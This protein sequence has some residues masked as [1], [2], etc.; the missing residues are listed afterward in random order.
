[1]K[2]SKLTAAFCAI[3]LMFCLVNSEAS[4]T[5]KKTFD[6]VIING[7]VIN[8]ETKLDETGLN[9]G[10]NGGIVA[11]LTRER[12]T[13]QTVIDA[14]GLVVSPGFIDILSYNPDEYGVWYKIA[15]GVTTNLA[16]HGGAVDALAWYAAFEKKRPPVN[17][18]AG[19]F[20]NRA[21]LNLGIGQYTPA[22][23]AQIEKLRKTAEKALSNGALGIGMSL[24][25]APGTSYDEVLAMTTVAA[26][27][28]VPVF[29]HVRYSDIEPPGTNIEA[30]TEV[31]NAGRATGASVHIDHIT[32]TGGTFSMDETLRLI[33]T[34]RSEGLDITACAYPYPY[35]GTYLN[36]ARFDPGWQKRFRISYG[37]LHIAG[38][39][40]RLSVETFKK[41]R[42]KGKLAVAYAIPDADVDAA[43]KSPFVMIGSDGIMQPGNN[44]HPRAA[45]AFSRTIALYVREKKLLTLMD[46][47]KK[48]TILPARRLEAASPAMRKKGRITAGADADIVIFDPEKIKDNATVASPNRFSS[49]IE[50]VIIAGGIVKDPA[51]FRKDVRPGRALRGMSGS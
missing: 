40:E 29:F 33:N 13:G 35:W 42:A 24:E 26:K 30:V 38:T 15:D 10:I 14:S 7:R 45:G 44:N 27:F 28:R 5:E 1:M 22:T 12:I 4:A 16:M 20:Y 36:S 43:M 3:A 18:G 46:A 6:L 32:S 2:M 31:I 21:R 19:F 34:G 9:V 47:L 25:Y 23:K 17:F 48:M 8:P 37:D 50:Y 51:G 11:E 49:G 39:D 41:Y